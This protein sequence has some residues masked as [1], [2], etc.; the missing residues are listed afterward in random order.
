MKSTGPAASPS[1]FTIRGE[2]TRERILQ[3][4]AQVLA[5]RGYA[6][7]TLNDI[8]ERAN[9]KAGS[10]YYYFESREDLIR[11]IMVRGI[12][13]TIE[14]VSAAVDALG[15]EA[16]SQQKLA[17]AVTAHIRYLLTENDIAR[18]AI[19]TLGQAPAEVEGP[20]IEQHRVYGHYM[21]TLI[22]AAVSDGY[23]DP[24]VDTRI[25]RLLI[26][27]AAN[28]STAWYHAEG[29][30]SVDDIAELASR[31]A[32]GRIGPGQTTASVA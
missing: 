27:G 11:E 14:H 19:R 4:A 1:A 29:D 7:S 24:S 31:L 22:Q 28:W 30:A 15:P 26:V 12:N 3:S 13:E 17:A 10:L 16:T 8:A 20:S 32:T 5:E 23:L 25:L 6:G 2:S 9:T 18:A 21:S